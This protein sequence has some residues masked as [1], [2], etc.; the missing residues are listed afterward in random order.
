[1]SDATYKLRDG[2]NRFVTGDGGGIELLPDAVLST[3]DLGLQRHLDQQPS[4]ERV[5]K[6]AAK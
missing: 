6:K 1:M 3:G 5:E 2:W 4:L